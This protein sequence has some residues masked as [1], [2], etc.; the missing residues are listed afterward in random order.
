VL[1]G[2]A[3]APFY[4][5]IRYA[6]ALSGLDA[7]LAHSAIFRALATRAAVARLN[8]DNLVLVSFLAPVIPLLLFGAFYKRGAREH[9]LGSRPVRSTVVTLL[10]CGWLVWLATGMIIPFVPA[11]WQFAGIPLLIIHELLVLILLLPR[12]VDGEVYMPDPYYKGSARGTLNAEGIALLK[13]AG[14]AMAT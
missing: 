6:S 14:E 5:A 2:I 10:L 7:V 12:V 1:I 9:E 11:A 8:Q 13:A 4:V 3:Y